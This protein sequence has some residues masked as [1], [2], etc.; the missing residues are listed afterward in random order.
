MHSA[1]PLAALEG[2]GE[3][4]ARSASSSSGISARRAQATVVP[5]GSNQVVVAQLAACQRTADRGRAQPSLQ[6]EA[7]AVEDI[8]ARQWALR[9]SGPIRQAGPAGLVTCRLVPERRRGR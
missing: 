3:R 1:A 6:L 7:I 8:P 9:M 4:E 2:L 5:G